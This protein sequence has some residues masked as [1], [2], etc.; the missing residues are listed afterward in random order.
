MTQ[1]LQVGRATVAGAIVAMA[2]LSS[3]RNSWS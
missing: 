3:W 2:T 1:F